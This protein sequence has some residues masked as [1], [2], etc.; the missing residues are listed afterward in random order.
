MRLKSLTLSGFKSFADT[1]E[2]TFDDAITGVVGPNG[3]G[4]SNV[5]DAIKWVLGE[6]SSKSLRGKEMIDVIFAGS[7]ARKP[8]GLAS[9]KLGFDNPLLT[10]AQLAALAR[11]EP[12][13]SP[14]A[15][16]SDADNDPTDHEAELPEPP[17]PD[18]AP[19]TETAAVGLNADAKSPLDRDAARR[20]GMPIDTDFVEVE[21]R[22]YRDGTSHYLINGRKARLKDIR[23]LFLDTGVGAD[24]YSIIEQ[25]K[26][27]AMLLA[28]PQDRR[29][30]FEEAAGIARYKQRRLE[31]QRKLDK[32][33]RNLVQTREQLAATERRLRLVKGQA[34]KARRF[35]ALDEERRALRAAIAF[36]R[37]HELRERLDGLTSRLAQLQSERDEAAARL[38]SLED[39]KRRAELARAEL[40]DERRSLEERIADAEHLQRQ[41]EQREQLTARSIEDH[42]RQIETDR[43]RLAELESRI[44]QLDA[45]I[46]DAE[47]A[48][49]A[50]DAE[51]RD[52]EQTLESAQHERTT[53]LESLNEHHAELAQRESRAG[54]IERERTSL[55]ASVQADDRRLATMR[56]Q[57]DRADGRHAAIEQDLAEHESTARAIAERIESLQSSIAALEHAA[58]SKAEAIESLAED[59]AALAGRVSELDERRVRLDARCSTLREMAQSRAGLGEAVRGVL[60]ARDAGEGFHGVIAPLAD[61]IESDADHARAIEAALGPTLRALVVPSLSALPFAEEMARLPGRVS[62]LPADRLATHQEPS[63]FEPIDLGPR[64][65]SL[66][67]FARPS[68]QLPEERSAMTARLL[69]RLLAR[70][71]LVRDL[72]EAA[73]LAAG[74]LPDWRLI[75]PD[76]TVLEPDGRV[77]T[78]PESPEAGVLQRKSELAALERELAGVDAELAGERDRL[79]STDAEVGRLSEARAE[80]ERELAE[81]QRRLVGEQSQRDRAEADGDRLRRD[82][83]SI[84]EERTQLRDRM[85][86]LERD[87]TELERKAESLAR[88]HADELAAAD[89]LRA[90]V[91]QTRS[92]HDAAGERVTS[93]KVD[94]SRLAEQVASARRDLGSLQNTRDNTERQQRDARAQLE[95]A[96]SRIAEHERAIAEARAQIERASGDRD[97]AARSLEQLAARLQRAEQHDQ[98]TGERVGV[99]RE[100]VRQLERDWNSVEISRRELEIK[101]E[102]AEQRASEEDGI[103]LPAEYDEYRIVVAPGDVTLVPRDQ[104]EAHLAELRAEIEKLGNVNLDAIEEEQNL[105]QRNEDLIAQVADLDDARYKLVDLIDRLNELSKTRFQEAFARIQEEFGGTSGMFRKLFGGGRAEIRLQPVTREVDGEKVQTD[106]ID[107]LE[108]GI[109]VLAKP[110]GKEPR[111][112]SQ[113]SGGEKTMTAVALLLSIFRSRPSCFCVLDEVDAALD[114]ANVDRFTHVVRQFTDMSHFIVITHNKRTMAAADRLYGVTMQERGVSKRVSVKFDQ[115][116]SNG[117]IKQGAGQAE[118]EPSAKP[119]RNPEAA[120][121]GST[122]REPREDQPEVHVRPSS[123]LA[124]SDE[125]EP[126][127]SR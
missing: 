119:A 19:G 87:R 5:V 47:S 46:A 14:D 44:E 49:E 83:T 16:R 107:P 26:V 27:D 13:T 32:A 12:S 77:I 110:P 90:R 105:A 116:G 93:A 106:Q 79:A 82:L 59:R 73:M 122:D 92:R 54:E 8:A 103:D 67:R 114:D 2:F 30:I 111:S 57:I 22:L 28:S 25:G 9:V 78:G 94:V 23:E 101:R 20:R 36:D 56:E 104:G 65:R 88:L 40:L 33:E 63:P 100:R 96:E 15:E 45:D 10:E 43:E 81:A 75:T 120:P 31:S 35:Q 11:Q 7:A 70:T 68:A 69:D 60:E 17:R 21:R 121:H 61:L 38:E 112:I 124:A 89:E 39:E 24:A 72:D 85:N 74:P 1:T 29:H 55:L 58:R 66:R 41:A 51:L 117:Q 34:A 18:D 62:F 37:Y 50:R 127:T 99:A 91:E 64:A 42:R 126:S 123:W 53:L 115:V 118:D 4:K 6:R 52:A 48:V 102:N 80:V 98:E 113:L 86:E 95:H 97:Q 125:A 84:D 109:D 76:G 71:S 108:S 3:C